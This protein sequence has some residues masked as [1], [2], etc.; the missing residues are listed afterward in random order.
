MRD[1]EFE[2]EA[3][4]ATSADEGRLVSKDDNGR[5]IRKRDGCVESDGQC[6][7]VVRRGSYDNRLAELSY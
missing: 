5:F 1:E 4:P 2:T 6:C 3:R 7:S